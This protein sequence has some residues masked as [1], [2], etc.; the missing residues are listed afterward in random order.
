MN[1]I[2][3]FDMILHYNNNEVYF[4]STPHPDAGNTQPCTS[5]CIDSLKIVPTNTLSSTVGE[6]LL[7]KRILY[8]TVYKS[9]TIDI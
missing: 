8:L 1:H 9:E 7:K 2:F 6:H 3:V 4:E 5:K